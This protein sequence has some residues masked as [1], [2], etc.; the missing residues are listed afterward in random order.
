MEFHQILHTHS[1]LPVFTKL[2]RTIG[3]YRQ[4]FPQSDKKFLM[5]DFLSQVLDFRGEFLSFGGQEKYFHVSIQI[6]ICPNKTCKNF[7]NRSTDKVF[8]A[9]MNFE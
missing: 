6:S 7:E 4:K 5:C 8:M 3:Q 2:R 1:Y 9:K